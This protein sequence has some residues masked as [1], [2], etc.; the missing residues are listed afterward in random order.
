MYSYILRICRVLCFTCCHDVT[1]LV[2]TKLVNRMRV[3][4]YIFSSC[5]TILW[6]HAQGATLPAMHVLMHKWA[7]PADRSWMVSAALAG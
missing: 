2:Y 4:P 7:P 6:L 5:Y 3:H 1:K